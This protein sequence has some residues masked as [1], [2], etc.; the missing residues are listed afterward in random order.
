MAMRVLHVSAELY[1]WVKSGGLG[2]VAAALP[3][4]LNALGVEIRLLLPGFSGF[5]DAFPEIADVARLATPFAPERVRVGLARL[6]GSGQFAYLVDHPPFYDRPGNPYAGPDG[7]DWPDNH[8]RFGLFGWIAAALARGA[9]RRW[10]PDIL[11][12]HDWHAGLAPAYLAVASPADR[13]APCLF[14]IHNIAYRGLFAPDTFP[15]LGLPAGFFAVD[16]VEF[17]GQVSFIKSGLF[18]ADRLTTVSP[19]Y[20]REIQT[21]DFAWGLDGLL[22]SRAGVLTGILNGVD[23]QV[24]DPR[25]DPN[26]PQAYGA[27]DPAAGK[28]AAKAAL[29]RRLGLDQREGAPLFGAVS[30]LTPQKG[31]DLLLAV[32]PQLVAMGGQLALLGSGDA[33]LERGFA[34]ITQ[35]HQGAV[36]VEL[37]YDE[38]LSHL[39][40]GGADIVVM[41]SRFEPCGLTQLY[42]LCY[43]SLPLVHRVGGLADTVVGAD[44]ASLADGTATGFTFD[45]ESPQAL[46]AA[47]EQ[48]IG[49][50]GAPFSWRRLMRRAMTRDFSWEAS[51]RQYLAL[52]RGLRPDLPS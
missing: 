15:E 29:Q 3:P 4:A 25:H 45:D 16:G 26:L 43:G 19:T 30:R 18:Y 11:H 42:A 14:T 48:A 5:L 7:R 24:W 36:A 8:R 13:P 31:L 40:I 1:P 10:R 44:A 39:I 52:Y 21:P 35:A 9:D 28:P 47:I 46:L 27:G 2:D 37:G 23:R 49:L 41:P 17:Y 12:C 34:T 50:F 38:A 33:D 32:A 20:A 22:R 51:A 6:P